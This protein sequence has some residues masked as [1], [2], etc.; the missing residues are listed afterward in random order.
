MSLY[1]DELSSII[2]I[3]RDTNHATREDWVAAIKLVYDARDAILPGTDILVR[4]Q[5]AEIV[6]YRIHQA[7]GDVKPGAFVQNWSSQEESH[8]VIYYAE[9]HEALMVSVNPFGNVEIWG[10]SS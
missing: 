8:Q 4:H 7:F 1:Q 2:K 9:R 6:E 10:L 5:D 3:E